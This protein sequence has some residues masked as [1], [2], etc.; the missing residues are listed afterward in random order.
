MARTV[1]DPADPTTM[2]T[3]VK[4]VKRSTHAPLCKK[5]PK[6]TDDSKPRSTYTEYT[7]PE[8]IVSATNVNLTRQR[9]LTA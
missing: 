6:P 7:Q 4:I 1:P 2:H 5:A 3:A 9:E 8:S